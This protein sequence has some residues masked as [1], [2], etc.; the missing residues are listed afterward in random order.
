VR[1]WNRL[2][3]ARGFV[4]L[5]CV[6]P[7]EDGIAGLRELLDLV[8]SGPQPCNLAVVKRFGERRSRGL[9]S[10]PMPGVTVAL[11]FANR[12]DA[13]VALLRNGHDIAIAHGGRV[14]PAKDHCMTAEAFKRGYP[15][16][17]ELERLRDPAVRSSFWRRTAEA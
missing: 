12:G 7:K 13:T 16:W 5:Q 1:H 11:D 9:L 15:A 8:S 3:G 6:F 17:T 2:Y 10:F 14:Y 4:Q